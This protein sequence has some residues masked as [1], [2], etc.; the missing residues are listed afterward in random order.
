MIA[1]AR[2]AERDMRNLRRGFSLLRIIQLH[3]TLT[4]ARVLASRQEAGLKMPCRDAK[5]LKRPG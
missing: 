1:G 2:Q 3:A 5:I 4:R